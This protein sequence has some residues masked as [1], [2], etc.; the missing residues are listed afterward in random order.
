MVLRVA[1]FEKASV[2][3]PFGHIVYFRAGSG[4]P[5]LFI[6]GVNDQAGTWARVAP[7]FA[8]THHVVV[9]DL[10]GHGDSDPQQG[11]LTG[12]QL[13]DGIAAVV[14]AE[15]PAGHLTVVGNSLGGFLALVN[16]LAG[17]SFGRLLRAKAHA[18]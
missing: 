17:L 7:A 3:V 12:T 16:L 1:G 13:A 8:A 9:A 11:D 18:R 5:L 4:P 2:P 6:H 10:A 15:A 14:A